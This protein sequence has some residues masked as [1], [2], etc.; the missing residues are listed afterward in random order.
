VS[1]VYEIKR[2]ENTVLLAAQERGSVGVPLGEHFDEEHEENDEVKGSSSD[3]SS[4]SVG[5]FCTTASSAA[6]ATAMF[7]LALASF[8][9][10]RALLELH[11]VV[12][13]NF[14]AFV[15]AAYMQTA[16]AVL[17]A[18]LSYLYGG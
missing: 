12:A 14:V 9:F 2:K 13:A 7:A 8:A 16:T 17:S 18:A 5:S 15:R 6:N 4:T 10:N 1:V 11:V 3:A